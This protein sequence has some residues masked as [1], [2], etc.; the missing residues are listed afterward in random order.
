MKSDGRCEV[1]LIDEARVRE[2]APRIVDGLRA[3]RL[4]ELFQALGDPTRVRIISALSLTEMCVCDLAASLSMS[5]SA[6]SHQLRLLRALRLVRAEK[7][8]R[9]VYYA[10]DD[11]HVS[12]LFRQG[13]EHVAHD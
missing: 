1:T 9:M 5:Q 3:T 6:I 4:A 12:G 2:V 7:R 10:L 8:G 11:A 13:M